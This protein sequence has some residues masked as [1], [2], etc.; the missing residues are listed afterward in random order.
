MKTPRPDAPT[1]LTP[2]P[3]RLDAGGCERL[4][5][6]DAELWWAPR[7]LDAAEADDHAAALRREVPWE[8]HMIRMFGRELPSPRLSCWVGDPHA[9]YTYSRT[10][11]EPR[12]WTPT[13]SALRARL[14]ERLG[15][16]FDSVLAN[17]YRDGR[18]SMGWHA[19]DEPELGP[20]PVIASI[21][22]GASRRFS[23]RHRTTGARRDIELT[24]G[25]L[26]VMAGATQRHWQHALPRAAGVFDE[27]INLTFRRIVRPR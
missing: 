5:L 3:S 17:R 13:L 24:H 1:G 14:R 25:S 22:L 11:F 15:I 4:P 16:D 7:F 12:A 18:D 26:L 9:A 6:A 10:R 2:D 19:D 20:E 21:S 8:T 23:F 27:R